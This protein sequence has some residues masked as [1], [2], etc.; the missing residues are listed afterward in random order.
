MGIRGNADLKGRIQS[1]SRRF[2]TL[3]ATNLLHSEQALN[4]KEGAFFSS[5]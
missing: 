1:K 3:D 5:D 2:A 4:E